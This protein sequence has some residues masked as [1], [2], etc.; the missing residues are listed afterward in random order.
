MIKNEAAR[1]LGR[2]Q[3]RSDE[4]RE[5]YYYAPAPKKKI[6]NEKNKPAA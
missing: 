4:Q 6:A 5:Y 2:L 1:V 3:P